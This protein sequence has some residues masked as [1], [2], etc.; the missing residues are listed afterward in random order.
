MG[1]GDEEELSTFW[2]PGVVVRSVEVLETLE[3]YEV[4]AASCPR[5]STEFLKEER[6]TLG[7]WCLRRNASATF[8]TPRARPSPA[9]TSSGRLMR[10]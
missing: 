4:P 5:I 8:L 2:G 7:E 9:P 6:R 3:R 10:R 1:E